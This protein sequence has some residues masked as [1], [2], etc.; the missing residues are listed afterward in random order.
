MSSEFDSAVNV[1][2][3]LVTTLTS[4]TLSALRRS[5]GTDEPY[6]RELATGYADEK[7]E[8]RATS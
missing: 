8:A 4:S 7:I 2:A 6:L 5:C 3:Y 1:C